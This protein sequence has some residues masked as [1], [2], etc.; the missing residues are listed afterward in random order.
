MELAVQIRSARHAWP[1]CSG[2]TIHRPQGLRVYTFLHFLTPVQLLLKGEK[3]NCPA[4]SCLFYD[5]DTPQWFQSKEPLRHDWMHMTGQIP[6]LLAEHDL[7]T[8]TLYLP[9]NSKFITAILREI[10]LELLAKQPRSE[11]LRELKFRELVLKLSRSIREP[12]SARN[13]KKQTLTV[14]RQVR[15]QVFA[16]LDHNWTV[17]EMANMSYISPSRFHAVY[18]E[19]FGI[20]PMED[21]IRA[22]IDTAKN[23]LLSGQ[24]T[25][26]QIANSLGYGNVTHFCRQFRRFTGFSP[27]EFASQ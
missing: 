27:K 3:I 9:G 20:S 25:V 11:I 24:E 18:R 14:L 8:D 15:Q 23:R 19:A 16:R 26:Q 7:A 22:R 1:E 6:H 13:L 2:F 5:L 17:A 10:E 12:D 4:G 21:L